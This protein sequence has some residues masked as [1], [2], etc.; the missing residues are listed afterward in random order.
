MSSKK[1]EMTDAEQ[2]DCPDDSKQ[3]ER[4][5]AIMHRLRA[6]G[7]CPWDAEQTHQ[8]LVGNLIEEQL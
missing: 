1:H 7:G 6:P 5:L 4:L 2:I 8:S 3:L